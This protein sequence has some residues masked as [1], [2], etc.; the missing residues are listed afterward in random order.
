M[1]E[2]VGARWGI[3]R[4]QPS[5]SDDLVDGAKRRAVE[6]WGANPA[7]AN[8][9]RT[10]AQGVEFYA[11]VER[12]RYAAYPW[13]RSYLA[14][15]RWAGRRVLEVGV[16]LGTDHVM[17]HRAGASPVV[18]VDLTPA[19]VA[20]TTCRLAIESF[21]ADVR[22]ADAESLPFPDAD[23][24]A[25]YSF[26]VLHHTPDM[27]R[28]IG[29]VRRVLRP[30]GTAVVALYNRHSYFV[31]WRLLRHLV[32]GDWRHRSLADMKADFEYGDGTPLV[33]LS[34]RRELRRLFAGFSS[35]S[36]EARHL[37]TNRVPARTRAALDGIMGPLERRYGWYWMI[38][39]TR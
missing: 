1:I 17:L 16:G 9:A 33:I 31:A 35:V 12:T 13:L 2:A 14:P 6:Q 28:A 27:A 19:S 20:H 37:P 3:D 7:G 15:T 25:V 11:E 30:G 23:F 22:L 36:I 24:D 39:A 5:G 26:G 10:A 4:P 32:R 18:G 38:E 29:E 8:L 21:D 34:T